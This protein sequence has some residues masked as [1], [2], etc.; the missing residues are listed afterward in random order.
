MKSFKDSR[1]YAT[2]A[3]H[4]DEFSFRIEWRTCQGKNTIK[5]QMLLVL[6]RHGR[7]RGQISDKVKD[8][9]WRVGVE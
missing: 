5:E 9:N 3:F 6:G 8:E 2:V 4:Q 7:N 1:L